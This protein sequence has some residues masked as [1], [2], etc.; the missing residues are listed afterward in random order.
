[1]VAG[2]QAPLDR[3]CRFG[4]IYLTSA[5]GRLTYPTFS[6]D[7]RRIAFVRER[8]ITAPSEFADIWTMKADGSDKRQITQFGNNIAWQ[9]LPRR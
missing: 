4:D 3:L 2:R 1:M 9:P 8:S 6:P 5:D 7:G